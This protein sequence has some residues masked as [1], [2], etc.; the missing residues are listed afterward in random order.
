LSSTN[1][2]HKFDKNQNILGNKAFAIST[3]NMKMTEK[4]LQN[5]DIRTK[6]EMYAIT[7]KYNH[8]KRSTVNLV[9]D[10]TINVGQ[11]KKIMH[12]ASIKTLKASDSNNF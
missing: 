5:Y 12:D 1:A 8:N 4:R 3:I 6:D 7:S 2:Y 10:S 11:L 9:E